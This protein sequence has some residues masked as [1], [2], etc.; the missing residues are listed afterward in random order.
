MTGDGEV[1]PCNLLQKPA[2]RRGTRLR[3]QASAPCSRFAISN[4]G[5]STAPVPSSGSSIAVPIDAATLRKRARVVIARCSKAERQDLDREHPQ[6]LLGSA[7]TGAPCGGSS[8]GSSGS[9]G[10]TNSWRR[11][12]PWRGRGLL[13]RL[14]TYRRRLRPRRT[15]MRS[16]IW[17]RGLGSGEL[18]R[19]V[20]RIGTR[21]RDHVDSAPKAR[22]PANELE[23][24]R[25]PLV[26]PT[27]EL[28]GTNSHTKC[29]T[30]KS[31]L[32]ALSKEWLPSRLIPH[33]HRPRAELQPAHEL[34][35]DGLG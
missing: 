4:K 33:R 23:T 6:R 25:H 22:G 2:L 26:S 9:C 13:R 29:N 8:W 12:S 31:P 30:A 5:A 11:S 15:R 16:T 21:L 20:S 24:H 35:V 32:A 18:P 28:G 1:I 7:R 27:L 3:V 19:C 14:T 17:S 10:L 34:Q